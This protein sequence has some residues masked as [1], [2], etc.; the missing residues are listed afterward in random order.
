MV[1]F[2]QVD[3]SMS[4]RMLTQLRFIAIMIYDYFCSLMVKKVAKVVPLWLR[5]VL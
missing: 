3:S 2:V 5:E 1:V 4:A